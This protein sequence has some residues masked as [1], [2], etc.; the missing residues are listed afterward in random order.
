MITFIQL[1]PEVPAGTFAEWLCEKQIPFQNIRPYAGDFLPVAASLSAVIV[2]GGAMGVHDTASFPFLLP[3]KSFITDCQ[4]LGVPYLGICLGGQLLA[5]VLGAPIHA[6]RH[7]EKGMQVVSQN[8][9]GCGDPLFKGIPPQFPTFQWHND[10]F[11]LPVGAQHLASSAACPNQAFRYGRAMYGLQF[12]P[13]VNH[14]I[15]TA[16]IRSETGTMHRHTLLSEFSAGTD[17]YFSVSKKLLDNFLYLVACF[18]AGNG[19][20]KDDSLQPGS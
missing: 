1:D 7:G 5:D 20:L 6:K 9:L 8:M 18:A 10:S 3:L 13:E 17:Y 14:Q 4:E 12:H 11:A 15:V 16:W 19:S 2:L